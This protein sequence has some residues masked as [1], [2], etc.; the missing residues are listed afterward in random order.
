MLISIF[1]IVSIIYSSVGLGGG[2]AYIALMVLFGISKTTLPIV[3]L[4]CNL[5]VAGTSFIHYH[6]EKYFRWQIFWPFAVTSIPLAYLGGRL[7]I[8]D[9]LFS[10]FLT[11]ALIVAALRLLFYTPSDKNPTRDKPPSWYYLF[12]I[13]AFL[14]LLAGI[15]GIGGGIYLIPALIL[16]KL[17]S[18]K[19]ASAVASL[20]VVVNSAS[21]LFGQLSKSSM[22]WQLF[23]PLASAVLVGGF[24]GSRLGV[25]WF[26]ASH[27]QKIIGIIMLAAALKLF[28]T[29]FII[30][31]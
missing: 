9:K 3:A 24:I 21:G 4:G 25:T 17:A 12:L 22:D 27:L 5:I 29:G 19:E 20:F 13:G 30:Q 1:F 16:L 6:R 2:S 26:R 14:G 15:T 7:H 18:Q 8:S 10:G 23:L 11:G 28:L 31:V